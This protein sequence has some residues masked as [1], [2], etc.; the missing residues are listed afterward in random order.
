MTGEILHRTENRQKTGKKVLLMLLPFWTPFIPPLGIACIKSYIKKYHYPVKTYDLNNEPEFWQI[1]HKYIDSLTGSIPE[2]KQGNIN[3]TGFDLLM[4]HTLA[5]MN[6]KGREDYFVLLQEMVFK[7]FFYTLDLQRV[8]LLDNLVEELYTHLENRL[9]EIF[10]RE[11]A[12]VLGLSV[13]NSNLGPSLFSVK[14]FKEKKIGSI[15]VLGGGIFSDQLHPDSFNFKNIM[16]RKGNWIDHVVIGEGEIIFLKILKGELPGNQKVFTAKDINNK[17]VDFAYAGGPDF[18][19]FNS[20]RYPALANYGSRSCPYQCKF[21]S[22]SLQ[23]GPFRKKNIGQVVDE[24][25]HLHKKYNQSLFL[26]SDSLLDPII[27]D[28]SKEFI[29]RG[30]VLYWDGYLRVSNAA[31]DPVNA[32]QW[33][34]GGFYRARLG[35][36]SGSGE[37]LKLMD[38][39]ITPRQISGTLKS[40]ARAGIKTTTY[41]VTGY[42]GETETNFQQTLDLIARLKNDI[43]SAE[44]HAF[45]FYPNGQVN[46]EK[47]VKEKG[48]RPLYSGELADLLMIQSWGLNN[49]PTGEEVQERLARFKRFCSQL[50]IPNPYNYTQWQEADKRWNRL[51]KTA[52]PPMLRLKQEDH[53]VNLSKKAGFTAAAISSEIDDNFDF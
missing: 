7:Y 48:V 26:L 11:Q 31:C 25:L 29:S 41:W 23:W 14:K 9:D 33:R 21:C 13:F 49:A 3:T 44:C 2:N 52:V 20:E 40:L 15:T 4:S 24:L 45:W 39:R 47:W 8:Q 53:A 16:K 27:T 18:D 30:I 32:I 36:E 34:S 6:K 37:I 35:I 10:A 12:D 19:D 38:K 46:S 51:H 1:H 43:F 42:P 50:E 5:Y 28:L 22:E 17:K